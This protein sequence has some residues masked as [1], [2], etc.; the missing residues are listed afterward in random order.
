MGYC[1]ARTMEYFRNHPNTFINAHLG[2]MG[3]DL[4]RLGKH[5]DEFP[6]VYTEIAAV[7]A[8]LG[9]QPRFTRE[10]L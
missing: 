7:I 9:R 10:F 4:E 5:L 8:E 6:N 1:D 2:W 3:N